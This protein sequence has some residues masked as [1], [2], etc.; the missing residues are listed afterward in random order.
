MIHGAHQA[1]AAAGKLLLIIDTE[2]DPKVEAAAIDTMHAR[3]VDAL[4]YATMFHR[5]IEPPKGLGE[6]PWVMLDSRTV[7]AQALMG[8][9]G[10]GRRRLRGDPLPH[11]GRPPAHRLP[12]R[13]QS[14][15]RRRGAPGGLP[16]RPRGGWHRVRPRAGG[17]GSKT[18]PSA[19][20]PLPPGFSSCPTRRQ[21]C[22]AT[23]TA[24]PWAPIAPPAM[25]GCP[26][27]TTSPSSDS[28]TR[29]RSRPTSIHRSPPS[30]CPMRR[31]VAGRSSTS[32]ESSAATSRDPAA[33]H[34]LPARG[35]RLGGA[36]PQR[37]G[38]AAPPRAGE[39]HGLRPGSVADVRTGQGG[40]TC[41]ISKPGAG[42]H[43]WPLRPW[44]LPH[45]APPR[46]WPRAT[47]TSVTASSKVR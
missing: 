42:W 27:R 12:Q 33:A 9:A 6:C 8:R 30:S 5:I 44:S 25:P 15:A 13:H 2:G 23:T 32:P 36:A 43:C 24:W 31:W 45:S 47:Q 21:P 34:G 11:R 19:D 17:R 18:T 16:A 10:R 4:I 38:T 37:G 46:W 28:T 3:Q 1:A 26:S 7:D 20:T 29:A 39:V 35:P 41:S 14:L 22:S 40:R